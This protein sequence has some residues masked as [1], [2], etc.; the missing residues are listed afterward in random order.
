MSQ[1]EYCHYCGTEVTFNTRYLVKQA[2]KPKGTPNRYETV[3]YCC[4][5]CEETGCA[6]Q[7]P[8]KEIK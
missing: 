4:E 5:S 6:T 1:R 7:L 2:T 8:D 3:G